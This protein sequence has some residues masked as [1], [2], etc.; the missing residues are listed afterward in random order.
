M[1]YRERSALS[2]VQSFKKEGFARLENP[3]HDCTTVSSEIVP[4]SAKGSIHT[5]EDKVE[6]IYFK[7]HFIR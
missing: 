6:Y 2:I 1:N 3:L 7:K 5:A 4:I